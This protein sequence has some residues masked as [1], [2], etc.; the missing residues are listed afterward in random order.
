MRGA[1]RPGSLC[2]AWVPWAAPQQP[3]HSTCPCGAY[4]PAAT[5]TTPHHCHLLWPK[6]PFGPNQSSG[7]AHTPPSSQSLFI[8]M[9]PLSPSHRTLRAAGEGEGTVMAAGSEI[10][11][12]DLFVLAKCISDSFSPCSGSLWP[13]LFVLEAL[14]RMGCSLM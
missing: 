9:C 3:N 7:S 5:N 10:E 2:Q 4:N 1:S 14:H 8:L 13:R 12:I 11:I 6:A